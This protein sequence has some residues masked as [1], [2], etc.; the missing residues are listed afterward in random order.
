[1][2]DLQPSIS[3]SNLA[4]SDCAAT[5]SAPFADE[6][7]VLTRQDYIAL[8]SEVN[9]FRS[10]H[11]RALKRER[12]YK[13]RY[14]NL[15]N[16]GQQAR[17]KREAEL[18][19]QLKA[20]TAKNRD[21]NQRLF[22]RHSEKS[23]GKDAHQAH[24]QAC[25]H[26]RKKGHQSGAPNH[27]R[28]M[29][30]DLPEVH[31][32]HQLSDSTCPSCH[33]PR[34][35][36]CTSEDSCVIE[37]EVKA[38]VRKIHRHLYIQSCDCPNIHPI[39]CAPVPPK[40]IAKGKYG[41]SVWSTVL[42]DKYKYGCPTERLL[43][44]LRDIGLPI[45]PGTITDGLQK[46]APLFEPIDAALLK[47]LRA[48][49]HW[50]ADETRWA[51]F[52]QVAGKI[53][54]RW[55]LWVF[56]SAQVVHYVLDQSRATQVIIDEFEG[57]DGGIIS[58][59][60]YSAYKSFVRQIKGFELA[61]CWV[62]QRRDFLEL[63]NSYPEHLDWAFDWVQAIRHLYHLNAL[64]LQEP[65]GS[66]QR[67][68]A[69]STLE[70]AVQEMADKRVLALQNPK[71]AQPCQKVLQSMHR[72]WSGLTLFVRNSHIPMDNNTAERDMRGPVVGRKNF[73][74]SGALWSGELA[75]TL[76]GLFATLKLYGIN[77]STW[78]VAYLQACAYNGAQAPQDVSSFL[79][80]CMDG[81]RLQAMRGSVPIAR[82]S[83][84]AAPPRSGAPAAPAASA[85]APTTS[86][87]PIP[88][89]QSQAAQLD[90]S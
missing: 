49:Q 3:T 45:A 53:G 40:L 21:L 7:I 58:C 66:A 47:H 14:R 20:V 33:K 37:I 24:S 5:A 74:G 90:T 35:E 51:M 2:H 23:K 67:A 22:G 39:I 86:P 56:H 62:H 71:L 16:L 82:P 85:L 87:T 36:L 50:H 57:V 70:Q 31:E 79:P 80:W 48:Q 41:I 26:P 38:H 75:A 6:Q 61:F 10:L 27:G 46:I 77:A 9:R 73:F 15:L 29:H 54:H 88:R 83:V 11:E 1:M 25:A 76:F 81:D 52:L 63:A 28:T 32:H 89:T 17:H 30:T 65:Q 42:L 13:E 64:R 60:R 59:D 12:W 18:I 84:A 43:Q 68:Q 34:R 55:Y 44:K 69:Q 8:L 78:M 72:H 19:E 4:P